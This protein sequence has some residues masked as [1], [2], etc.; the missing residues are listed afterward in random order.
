M[1]AAAAGTAYRTEAGGRMTPDVWL[2]ELR[3]RGWTLPTPDARVIHLTPDLAREL[4][5]RNHPTRTARINR[6]LVAYYARLMRE[7]Q[8]T[9]TGTPIRL[10]QS[11]NLIDGQHRLVAASIAGWSGRMLLCAGIPDHAAWHMDPP[12]IGW[13]GDVA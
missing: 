9:D 12:G 4:F 6:E 8:W 13:N 11:G 5:A 7:G 2:N 3:A 1:A 10:N